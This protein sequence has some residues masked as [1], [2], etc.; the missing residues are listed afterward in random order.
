MP[1]RDLNNDEKLLKS[2]ILEDFRRSMKSPQAIVEHGMAMASTVYGDSWRKNRKKV[3]EIIEFVIDAS[4][5]HYV[6]VERQSLGSAL[7]SAYG[8]YSKGTAGDGVREALRDYSGALDAALLSISQ[9]RKAR[10]GSAFENVLGAFFQALG[11]PF[12]PQPRI[13]G[14]PDFVF[15]SVDYYKQAAMDC[16]VFTAKTTLRERWRQIT[17]EGARGGAMY[18]ATLDDSVKSSDIQEMSKQ[19]I[20]LVVPQRLKFATYSEYPNVISF[21]EFFSLHL[22]PALRRWRV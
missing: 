15:P 21:E 12:T 1:R 2:R 6:E 11:Y 13:D 14:N 8:M 19:R 18:L 16:I 22:D 17:S 4:Y 7:Y 20:Y 10:A 9:G 3:S 5:S